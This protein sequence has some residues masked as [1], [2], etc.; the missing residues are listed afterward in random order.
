M[1]LNALPNLGTETTTEECVASALRSATDLRIRL[2]D[3]PQIDL[4]HPQIGDSIRYATSTHFSVRELARWFHDHGIKISATQVFR[5]AEVLL[6]FQTE[7][8]A[9]ETFQQL[10]DALRWYTDIAAKKGANP[11]LRIADFMG[12]DDAAPTINTPKKLKTAVTRAVDSYLDA[13]KTHN[14]TLFPSDVRHI[15]LLARISAC[16]ETELS[17]FLTIARTLREKPKAQ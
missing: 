8:Q 5:K 10:E 15:D 11:A 14:C 9:I 3:S 12:T 2:A 16:T 6:S 1:P 4:D 7:E 17:T 13:V